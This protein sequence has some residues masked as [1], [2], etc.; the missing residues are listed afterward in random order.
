MKNPTYISVKYLLLYF[1]WQIPTVD[2]MTHYEINTLNMHKH[3]Q[4]LFEMRGKSLF[5]EIINP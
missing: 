3:V 2:K 1:K 5:I 4:S